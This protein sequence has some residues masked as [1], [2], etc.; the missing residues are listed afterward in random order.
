MPARSAKKKPGRVCI[1]VLGMHRSGTSAITGVLGLAGATLPKDLMEA[2]EANQTGY[3]ESRA[4]QQR[5]DEFLEDWDSTWFDWR[6]FDTSKLSAAQRKNFKLA[7]GKIIADDYGDAP[8]VV[9]KDPRV[10]RFAPLFIELL[11]EQGFDVRIVLPLRHP[12]EVCDS[13]KRRDGF[14]H[15]R[16]ALLWLRHVLDA[17]R[18]SRGRLRH[19]QTYH[20]LLTA[21]HGSLAKLT[22]ALKLEWPP[23]CADELKVKVGKFLTADL[24]HHKRDPMDLEL[25]PSLGNWLGQCY[26]ALLALAEKPRSKTALKELDLVREAFDSAAPMI[27]R[28]QADEQEKAAAITSDLVKLRVAQGLAADREKLLSA[29]VTRM[30]VHLEEVRADLGRKQKDHAAQSALAAQR[31]CQNEMLATQL[32]EKQAELDR[33]DEQMKDAREHYE[34]QSQGLRT[35]LEEWREKSTHLGLQLEEL[36]R[37]NNRHKSLLSLAQKR[38]DALDATPV[39][40]LVKP[41]QALIARQIKNQPGGRSRA[42]HEK[43]RRQIAASGFFDEDYYLEHN[44][45]VKASGVDALDHYINHG[46]IEGRAASAFFDSGYYLN[47]NPAVH[48]AGMNALIHYLRFGAE[49]GREAYKVTARERTYAHWISKFD[50]HSTRDRVALTQEIEKLAHRP[51]ISVIVPVYNAPLALLD[52]AIGSVVDQIYPNWELCI[53][54]DCSSDPEVRRVLS[55]WAE[56]EPRIKLVFREENGHICHATNSAFALA[57]GT[58]IALLD[59]DDVLREHALAEVALEISR[60]PEAQLFYSDEDKLDESGNRYDPYFKP[61]FSRELFR[62]QNYLNHLTVHKADNIRRVGGWRPGYEGS[63]D[64][65]LNLR[66]FEQIGQ[67]AIRHIP[68]VLYHWRAVEGSTARTGEEKSY[69]FDAGLKALED[70]VE[71]TGLDASVMPAPDTPF[72]RLKLAVPEPAPLVSLIIPTRDGLE[73]LRGCVRSILSRTTYEN[74]EIII[75]DNGS[76]DTG[77]LDYMDEISQRAN[78]RVLKYDK[79]FNYSA[80]NNFAVAQAHGSIVGLINNDIEV[81]S[82]DWLGE[83]VSWSAQAEIGCVGAKLFYANDTVQHAGV[84]LGL[85]GVAGHSHK[86]FP[87]NHAGYFFRLQVLQNYSAVTAACL[88]VRKEVYDEVG[89]LNAEDLT[90]AFNDVDFCLKVREAGYSNVWS[91]FAELYHLESI[92]RGTDESPE[93]I[94]RFEKEINF[95]KSQWG[96]E[97]LSDPYYSP[98]LSTDREDFSFKC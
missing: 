96:A 87:R 29:E 65:D 81:I 82:P 36:D 30:Q 77:T 14:L 78:V 51:L 22:E 9:I 40:R 55:S 95:M 15:S 91:P 5:L 21:P 39:R 44:P 93:R 63:Q 86:H 56:R 54:D 73:L 19:L 57:N 59:H 3:W 16:S 83:M 49:E 66:I 70:H 6:S 52:E 31:Q 53:A 2:T 33:L 7:I 17:E 48:E 24:R 28:V 64:Y 45:D 8:L 10:C 79:P 97:L 38:A 85:G 4:L 74:Y 11:E 60:H 32:Q 72:Y 84:V 20:D 34:A 35:S 42:Q 92:S 80:I 58:W 18:Y 75:V 69:A 27:F 71:R 43:I 50:Y 23:H 1:L 25:E 89:G 37:A 13:L 61:A 12:L 47:V 94:E 98:H 88:L 46:G 41:V 67:H 26:R 76:T 90:V 62:S 68:K